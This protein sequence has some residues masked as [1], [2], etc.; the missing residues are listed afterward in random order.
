[1][2]VESVLRDVFCSEQNSTTIVKP[3]NPNAPCFKPQ[4]T[5]SNTEVF[6]YLPAS[7]RVIAKLIKIPNVSAMDIMP[8]AKH[9]KR[10]QRKRKK[11]ALE[12]ENEMLN[13]K[14]FQ[15]D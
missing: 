5:L 9:K 4:H 10:T 7:G 12:E 11:L 6:R 2:G 1:M 15:L 3:L 8:K 14:L 13:I